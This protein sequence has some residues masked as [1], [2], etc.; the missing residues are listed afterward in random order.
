MNV[1]LKLGVTTIFKGHSLSKVGNHCFSILQ[2]T[3]VALASG[4]WVLFTANKDH[5]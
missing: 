2:V 5:R 1:I 3:S 4:M